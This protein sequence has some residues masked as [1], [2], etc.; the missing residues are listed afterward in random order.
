[1]GRFVMKKYLNKYKYMS[2]FDDFWLFYV[3]YLKFKKTSFKNIFHVHRVQFSPNINFRIFIFER[4]SSQST[5]PPCT[6][7]SPFSFRSKPFLP[8]STLKLS[9]TTH[10]PT[11]SK[12]I[13]LESLVANANS[14]LVSQ[15]NCLALMYLHLIC[16]V[17]RSRTIIC[18]SKVMPCKI[19]WRCLEQQLS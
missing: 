15:I 2:Q 19:A 10:S 11:K 13:N 3:S 7:R 1:M 16:S 4:T 12:L 18:P 6:V 17:R 8:W 9:N 5:Y 14:R